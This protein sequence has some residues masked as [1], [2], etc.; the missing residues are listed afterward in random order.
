MGFVYGTA[1]GGLPPL[2]YFLWVLR[3]KRLLIVRYELYRVAFFVV[4]AASTYLVSDLLLS[5]LPAR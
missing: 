4:V 5:L 3:E 2:L 1:L